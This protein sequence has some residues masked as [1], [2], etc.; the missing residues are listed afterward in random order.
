M[1]STRNVTTQAA[2][3]LLGA[4]LVA[5]LTGCQPR[6]QSVLGEYNAVAIVPDEAMGHRQ[7]S[8]SSLV[9][10]STA[11]PHWS[12]EFAFRPHHDL[13]DG[14]RLILEPLMFCGQ[15]LALP[16]MLVVDPP[17]PAGVY[18]ESRG[19]I[20]SSS[21][22]AN[23]PTPGTT[24]PT[25]TAYFY[26]PL[27]PLASHDHP[28][29]AP[30]TQPGTVKAAAEEPVVSPAMPSATQPSAEPSGSGLPGVVPIPNP[31]ANPTGS[32]DAPATGGG[33]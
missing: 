7:W 27:S 21:W 28:V 15:V 20:S 4:L 9:Y 29:V 31:P 1:S 24:Q 23:P 19:E 18:K 25:A 5:S 30:T 12:T 6:Q 22:T 10:T 32:Q 16:V 26:P 2:S 17:P 33:R 11:V 8:E 14:Q 13:N 3:G